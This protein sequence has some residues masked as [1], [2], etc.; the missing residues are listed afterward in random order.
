MKTLE[1]F[2]AAFNFETLFSWHFKKL[3]SF[4]TVLI[5]LGFDTA[6]SEL[7]AFFLLQA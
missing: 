3:I 5:L 6:L 2:Q 4:L 7:E 1:N